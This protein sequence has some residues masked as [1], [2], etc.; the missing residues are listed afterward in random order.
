[1][2]GAVCLV[3]LTNKFRTKR[4][5]KNS[6]ILIIFYV[7]EL[8]LIVFDDKIRCYHNIALLG[9]FESVFYP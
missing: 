3:Q 9:V 5:W 7:K 6:G 2:K 1:M 4:K 8:H